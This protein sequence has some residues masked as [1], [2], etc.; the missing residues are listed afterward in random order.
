VTFDS[1]DQ[2]H[3]NA[4]KIY[5]QVVQTKAMPLANLTNMTDAERTQIAAWYESGAK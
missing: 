3:Q 1:V 2:I 5:K 4:E